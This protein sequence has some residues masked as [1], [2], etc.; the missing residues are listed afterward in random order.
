MQFLL[1]DKDHP[2]MRLDITVLVTG[3]IVNEL[4][5]LQKNFCQKN[6]QKLLLLQAV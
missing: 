2:V 5:V 4:E 1:N 3:I 6:Y